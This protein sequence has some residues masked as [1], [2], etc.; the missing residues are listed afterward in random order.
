MKNFRGSTFQKYKDQRA[1]K[2]DPTLNTLNSE[3]IE[4]NISFMIEEPK[5]I[6]SWSVNRKERKA[7]NKK[8]NE[9]FKK[10][11]DDGTNDCFVFKYIKKNMRNGTGGSE[12]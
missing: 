8:E 11:F 7:L 3:N 10:V 6:E 4:K 1:V 9:K 2:R 5:V 12:P